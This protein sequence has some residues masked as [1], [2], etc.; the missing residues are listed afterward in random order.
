VSRP[1][2]PVVIEGTLPEKYWRI[3]PIHVPAKNRPK[4]SKKSREEVFERDNY[5]CLHCGT[6]QDLTID[7]IRPLSKGGKNK[8][9]NMQTLCKQCNLIKADKFKGDR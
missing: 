5:R 9:G 2:D 1:K 7:H 3:D 4:V 6:D 8:K